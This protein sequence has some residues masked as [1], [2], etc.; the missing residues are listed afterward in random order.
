VTRILRV[1]LFGMIVPLL[2]GGPVYGPPTDPDRGSDREPRGVPLLVS[3]F[4]GVRTVGGFFD[5]DGRR[6]ERQLAFDGSWVYGKSGHVAYDFGMPIG[7]PVLAAGD[8][9]VLKARDQGSIYCG[10]EL[11]RVDSS[12]VIRIVHPNAPDGHEY[13]TFYLHLSRIDV[14]E[15]DRVRA[16]QPIGLS[17]NTGCSHGPHLHFGVSRVTDPTAHEGYAVDPFGWTG[18]EPDPREAVGH[19]SVWLW[20]PGREP[21]LIRSASG[22]RGHGPVIVTELRGTD[23]LDSLR[24]EYVEVGLAPE[25][26]QPVPLGGWKLRNDAGLTVALPDHTLKPGRTLRIWT[27]RTPSGTDEATFGRDRPLWDDLGECVQLVNPAGE[28]T[29][30]V[31]MGRASTGRAECVREVEPLPD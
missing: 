27:N 3:P 20:Q 21:P 15:G 10:R 24:G 18:A 22:R 6:Y 31:A 23:L 13:V 5:H 1:A 7:T 26:K 2:L 28:V 8:G 19:P 25:V 29:A 17:G 30:T 9:W 4:E 16:G 12:K 11:G 14:R